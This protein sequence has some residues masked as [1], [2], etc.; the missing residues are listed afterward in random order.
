MGCDQ[1]IKLNQSYA[2]AYCIKGKTLLELKKYDQALDNFNKAI[3]LKQNDSDMYLNRAIYYITQAE[4]DNALSDIHQSLSLNP[5]NDDGWNKKGL[6]E[7]LLENHQEALKYFNKAIELN[8]MN[9]VAWFNIG[10]AYLALGQIHNC[11]EPFGKA[12]ILKPGIKYLLGYHAFAKLYIAEWEGFENDITQIIYQQSKGGSVSTPF[13]LFSMIDDPDAHLKSAKIWFQDKTI[14]SEPLPS[15]EQYSHQKLRIGY[16]SA[17]FKYHPVALL[18]AEIFEKHDRVKFEVYG[19]SL[20]KSQSED[21]VRARLRHGFDMFIDVS[22]KTDLEIAKIAREYEIDLAIDLGGYTLGSR[23]L[24]FEYRAAPI[25]INYLGYPGTMG[26]ENIDYIITD[27]TVIPE[28]DQMYY[29]EKVIYKPNS[30]I[31][32]DSNRVASKRVFT[33]CEQGLPET[34]FIY[35]CFNNSYKFNPEMADIWAKILLNVSNSV[36]WISK[37]NSHFQE[38]ILKE[39]EKR[40]IS[41]ERIIFAERVELMSDHLAR[42]KLADLFLD[43]IPYNAHTTALDALKSG[44]PVLTRIGKSFPARVAASFLN[45]LKMNDLVTITKEEYIE[46]AI[47]IGKNPSKHIQ[48]KEQLTQNLIDSPLFDSTLFVNELENIY[49]KLHQNHLN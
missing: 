27:Q 43:T 32:D 1:A 44:V 5:L 34:G 25:Q 16:F 8:P 9:A 21:E 26:S 6:L 18:M 48:I 31:P 45:T 40:N 17:D 23:P 7:M 29:S 15:L 33:K 3:T 46:L 28:N 47:E 2:M 13:V 30:F 35:C 42:Y 20:N 4:V 24:I 36:L 12:K 22:S 37:N 41:K 38:N 14:L 19:F 10:N 11:L 49:V 39:F